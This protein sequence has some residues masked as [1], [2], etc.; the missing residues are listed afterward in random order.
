LQQQSGAI[1][2]AEVHQQLRIIQKSV[3]QEFQ[4]DPAMLHLNDCIE[5]LERIDPDPV[6]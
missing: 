2:T 3:D 5:E 4:N 6:D 1:S